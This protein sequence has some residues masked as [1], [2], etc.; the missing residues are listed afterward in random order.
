MRGKFDDNASISLVAS[1]RILLVR[2]F[3]EERGF[4]TPHPVLDIPAVLK[5]FGDSGAVGTHFPALV[6]GEGVY[7]ILSLYSFARANIFTAN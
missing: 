4:Y 7:K 2:S 5:I 3:E 6:Y 1:I